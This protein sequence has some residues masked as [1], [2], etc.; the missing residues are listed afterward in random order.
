MEKN[1]RTHYVRVPAARLADPAV[2]DRVREAVGVAVE[3]S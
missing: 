1:P 2:A 3:R